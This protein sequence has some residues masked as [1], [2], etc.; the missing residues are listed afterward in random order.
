MNLF[1]NAS[2]REKN[3]FKILKDI[4]GQEDY[5]SSL[6]SKNIEYCKV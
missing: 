5:F 3:C 2:N 4:I 1:I 6:S